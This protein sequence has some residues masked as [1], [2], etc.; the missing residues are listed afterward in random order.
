MQILA[1]FQGTNLSVITDKTTDRVTFF[2]KKNI[3]GLN[4]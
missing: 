4:Y 1:C 3:Q 2:C